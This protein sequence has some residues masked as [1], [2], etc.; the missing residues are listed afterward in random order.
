MPKSALPNGFHETASGTGTDWDN[1]VQGWIKKSWFAYGPRATEWWARWR[2]KPKPLFAIKGKG[3]WRYEQDGV[4]EDDHGDMSPLTIVTDDGEWYLTC[5]QYWCKWH[6]QIQWPLFIAFHYYFDE[7][8]IH[9]NN[10]G[11]K[12][13]IYIRFGA[14]R[15]ADKV[16]WFP[17]IFVGLTWN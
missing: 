14:R 5:I 10:Y 16:Y 4:D 2:A 9:P 17:S 15:D 12:R 3:E 6:F 7:T 13:M 1:P 8:P 11:G